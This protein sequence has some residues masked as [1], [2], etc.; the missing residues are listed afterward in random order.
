MPQANV[1]MTVRSAGSNISII[2]IQ[3]EMT[4]FA[5]NALTDAY[6]QASANGVKAIL[7]NFNQL[8]Y[9][10]SSGIGLL[11]TML[12]RAQRHGQSLLACGLNEHYTQIF[13]LTRLNDAIAI[14]PSEEAALD[15]IRS[16]AN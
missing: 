6:T 9:M 5:E 13:E 14:H 4:G 11:V 8:D 12:I 15:A 3:G 7:L 10:N 16:H 1:T 2:D